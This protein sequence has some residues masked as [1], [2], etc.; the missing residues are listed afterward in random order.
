MASNAKNLRKAGTSFQKIAGKLNDE[1]YK[2]RKGTALGPEHPDVAAIYNNLGLAYNQKGEYDKAV[3][4]YEKSLALKLKALGAE[5]PSV[6]T[7]Y[8]N[9]G[10]AYADK[11]DKA[12][13]MAY[14]LKAKA[15]RMKKLGP[16]HPRTKS[17]QSWIDDL[18]KE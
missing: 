10:T 7:T 16:E 6:G 12:K 14:L 4:Y 5:H 1:G 8:F 9:M 11:G 15:I 18:N 13:A 17:L 3:E 2:N